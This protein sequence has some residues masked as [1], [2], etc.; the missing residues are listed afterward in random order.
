MGV[1]ESVG[2]AAAV[3]IL[4]Q[5]CGQATAVG[6]V[7]DSCGEPLLTPA[8]PAP[9]RIESETPLDRGP[10]ARKPVVV[11]LVQILTLLAFV[12]C[13]VMGVVVLKFGGA[14]PGVPVMTAMK[15]GLVALAAVY[16]VVGYG[17]GR[18]ARWSWYTVLLGGVLKLAL[19]ALVI[20]STLLVAGRAPEQTTAAETQRTIV[21]AVV[22]SGLMLWLLVVWCRRPSRRWFGVG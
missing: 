18:A 5:R 14:L 16:G 3:E 21:S 17:V 1:G 6:D 11:L 2:R 19:K 10:A 12:S 15:G 13:L 9:V 8:M 4:C 22:Q 20:I 7:C